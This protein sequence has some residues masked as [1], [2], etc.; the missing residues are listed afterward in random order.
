VRQALEADGVQGAHG[1]PGGASSGARRR[2]AWS[3]NGGANG[4]P[5]WWKGLG[6][7]AHHA[8]ELLCAIGR[9]ARLEGYGLDT[10]GIPTGRTIDTNAYLQTLFPNI[11]AVGDAAGPWQFTHTAAHQAW[12]AAVNALF[13][14]GAL[15]AWMG[16]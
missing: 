10:L 11:Y 7:R 1:L 3:G 13:G 12:Y 4:W 9:R 5:T 16:G 14:A 15:Q 6:H 8:D 2:K